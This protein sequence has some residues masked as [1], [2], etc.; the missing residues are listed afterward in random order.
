MS[1]VERETR[2]DIA[3]LTL[4]NPPV[5]GL[6]SDVR[7]GLKQEI[8]AAVSDN[9]VKGIVIAG[10]GRMFCAGADIK[11]FDAVAPE[12]TPDLPSLLDWMEAG[13][14]P[15]VAAIH[16][17]ALGGGC[18]VALACHYRVATADT[19]VGL[20]EVTLGILPG[21]GGTQRMPRLVGLAKAMELMTSGKQVP[22]AKAA[23]M[24]IID[25]VVEGDVLQAAIAAA[26]KLAASGQ[27]VRRTAEID[28]HKAEAEANPSVF[29]DFAKSI[30]RKARGMN[31][32]FAI[33]DCV[34]AS[35]EMPFAE[36]R[37]FE[38]QE[39]GKLVSA[40]EGKSM[41]HAF[42]AERECRKIPDV[43]KDT[44]VRP[45]NSVAML[46]AGTMGGG[47]AMNFANAGIPVTM[48]E[49]TQEAL[50]RGLGILKKNYANTVAKGRLSQEAMDQ[51]MAVI[52]GQ[53]GMDGIGDADI[54]IE[55]V[56]EN[57]ALKKEIFA[58]LDRVCKP[59]AILATNTSTLDIDEIAS[60]TSR[61]ESVVGTHFFSPANVMKLMENVRGE[62][63][64]KDV[65]ATVMGLSGRIGKIGVLSGVCY[66]FIGNRMLHQYI[67]EAN[68]L[69]EEGALPQQIDK[70]IYDFG[71]PMGPFAMGDLAGLDVSWRIR[72]ETAHLRSNDQRY[73]AVADKVCEMGRFGQK[74]GGGWYDY[75]EGSRTPV[76]NAD[77]EALI[78]AE[79]KERDI[80]RR[81]ISDAEILERCMYPLINEGAKILEE[82][83]ALRSSD[84]DVVWMAGYGFPRYRGGPMFYADTVGVDK[85]YEVMARLH[86]EHGDLVK[87]APLLEKLANEGKSF[88]DL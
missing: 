46:G 54:V 49:T 48:V 76:P 60:A 31:A 18:E 79:S 5:N 33:I 77:I 32:P 14:K 29:D 87:P 34:R 71:L 43:P 72:Q 13:S 64:A 19:K 3:I 58:E 63:T 50:D 62:K 7:I 6:G 78:I 24:G 26:E 22:A 10:A 83:I 42:F 84:I 59:E 38:R 4:N 47:I 27:G 45:I 20:P 23:A 15:I 66:G 41:R 53:V 57:M 51:R 16:G 28:T 86:S 2:G 75:K 12:G 21:A 40:D 61:P 69:L 11:E 70:V 85:V 55:A 74:T 88:G 73:T 17:V 52:S 68:F 37:E 44:P 36:G 65:I 56:F 25:E 9:A 35:V 39:F 30:A 8:E 80:E 1:A 81:E 67:R 82:G